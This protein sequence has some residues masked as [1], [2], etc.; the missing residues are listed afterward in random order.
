M[1]KFVFFPWATMYEAAVLF[2]RTTAGS[3][4]TGTCQRD[5]KYLNELSKLEILAQHV[6]VTTSFIFH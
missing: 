3:C 6:R 1:L 4:E 5:A 2:I